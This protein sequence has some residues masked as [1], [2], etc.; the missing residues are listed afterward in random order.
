MTAPGRRIWK[1]IHPWLIIDPPEVHAAAPRGHVLPV[2]H[3]GPLLAE[4]GH[5]V[6][7]KGEGAAVNLGEW[8]EVERIQTSEVSDRLTNITEDAT[9][10]VAAEAEY[11]CQYCQVHVDL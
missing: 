2:E 1:N 10:H 4:H 9:S 3:L 11:Y 5:L 7:H 8:L 6:P